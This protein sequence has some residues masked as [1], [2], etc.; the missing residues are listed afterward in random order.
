MGL[1]KYKNGNNWSNLILD[2][3]YPVGTYYYN[4]SAT[5]SPGSLFGGVWSGPVTQSAEFPQSEDYVD[6]WAD[7]ITTNLASN[8]WCFKKNTLYTLDISTKG[9]TIKTLER[10]DL[11]DEEQYGWYPS[12]SAISTASS[13]SNW[14]T[15]NPGYIKYIPNTGWIRFYTPNDNAVEQKGGCMSL[16]GNFLY[17]SKTVLYYWKRTS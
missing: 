8:G 16:V 13:T 15:V 7:E 2:C 17:T 6:I 10:F 5:K 14:G 1:I 12:S 9:Y 11:N 3:V 4:G